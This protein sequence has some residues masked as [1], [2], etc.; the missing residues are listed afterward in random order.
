MELQG[1][2]FEC[3]AGALIHHA[4][5]SGLE[6]KHL[7]AFG[8]VPQQHAR[9][10]NLLHHDPISLARLGSDRHVI[11]RWEPPLLRLVLPKS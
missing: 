6:Q 1:V 8:L 4:A 10:K 11:P 5:A 3:I 9:V 7:L 2:H